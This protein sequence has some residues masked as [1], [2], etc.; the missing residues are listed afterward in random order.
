MSL[1]KKD[2]GVLEKAIAIAACLHSGQMR[3]DGEPYILHP[4]RVMVSLR[5]ESDS[6]K[7]MAVLH[8]TIEDCGADVCMLLFK[9]YG[10]PYAIVQGI[11]VL[12]KGE[13]EKYR[14]YITRIAAAG[15]PYIKIKLADIQ[16]NY[17]SLVRIPA[18]DAK[19]CDRKF[20]A[21]IWAIGFLDNTIRINGR[22][23]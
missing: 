16:D 14:D 7:A 18:G 3:K 13:D 10:I 22:T 15:D 6:V 2:M 5:I 8:D 21:Y 12:S 1:L 9:K 17:Y 23:K 19:W 11:K 4:I 20:R